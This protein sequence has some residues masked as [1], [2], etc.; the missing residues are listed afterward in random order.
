VLV[1]ED[2]RLVGLISDAD[3]RV[4]IGRS[5]PGE[6]LNFP[7]TDI[8]ATG[9]QTLRPDDTLNRAARIMCSDRIAAIP[10]TTRDGLLLSMITVA[11]LL[12]AFFAGT[13]VHA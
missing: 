1:V 12:R 8:M 13:P 3:V 5:E 7:L 11:D 4:A 10:I 2:G 6:W 9:V